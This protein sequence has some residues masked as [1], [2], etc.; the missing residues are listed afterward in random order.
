VDWKRAVLAH[1]PDAPAITSQTGLAI[2]FAIPD[3]HKQDLDNL[4]E[5]VLSVVVNQR[6]WFGGRRPNLQWLALSKAPGDALGCRIIPL[7]EAPVD[8]LPDDLA[9][10]DE[11]YLGPLPTSARSV[12]FAAWATE[13]CTM[14]GDVRY[15]AAI[16][17]G[18]RR[19]LGDIAT[20]AVKP[21]IDC[22]WP[23][24]GGSPRDPH[25]W[26]LDRLLL[27]QCCEDVPSEAIMISVWAM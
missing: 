20:G 26:R 1:V 5:P 16:S 13:R 15:A 12:E 17:F 4:A 25:D 24:W 19:N 8:W 7:D 22:L 2:E 9:V 27:T 11:I 23:L 6:G 10:I 3:P 18:G 21:I 14:G